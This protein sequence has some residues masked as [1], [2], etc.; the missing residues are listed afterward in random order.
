MYSFFVRDKVAFLAN[1]T[2]HTGSRK[3]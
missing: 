1:I 3:T 2:I